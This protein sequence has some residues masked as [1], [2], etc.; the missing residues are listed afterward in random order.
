MIADED[1]GV[2]EAIRGARIDQRLDGN[3]RLAGNKE[4]NQKRKVTRGGVWEG[5]GKGE[6]ATQPGSY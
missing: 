3:R 2:N 4:V 1:G 6:G 5:G